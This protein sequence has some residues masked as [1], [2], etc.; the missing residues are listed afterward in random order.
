[1][2]ASTSDV[3]T[4]IKNIV[5]TLATATQTYLSVNGTVNYPNITAPTV[6]STKT[7]RVGIVSVL[8]AGTTVGTIYDGALLTATTK[9]IA[10][11]PNYIGV[12]RAPI[13]VSF[14]I[15]VVPGIGQVVTVSYT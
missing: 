14:G 6:I 11:I 9:P 5:T 4:S 2:S 7:G 15:L 1:M 8:A 12:F 3:L 13:P 10:P